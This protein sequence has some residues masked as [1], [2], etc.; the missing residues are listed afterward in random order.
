MFPKHF[1][2]D[3]DI[4]AC[5]NGKTLGILVNIKQKTSGNILVFTNNMKQFHLRS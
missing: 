5:E 4:P 1:K 3:A 2:F